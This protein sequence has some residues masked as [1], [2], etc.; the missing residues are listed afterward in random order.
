M[1]IDSEV[2][3]QVT[4]RFEV[5][6]P[7]LNE[8]QRRLVLAEE[9]RLIGHGGVRAV[10]RAAGV[11]ETTVRAGVFEL[12]RGNDPLPTGRVRQPGGGRKPLTEHDPKLMPA[13]L[14]LVEPDERG[15]PT[16]PLRW[17]TKSL[18]HLADE[19]TRQGHPVSAATVGRLLHRNGF[20]LQANAKTLEGDQHADRD[21]QFGYVNEQ[22]K[23]HQ[24]A[25]EPVISVDAKKKEQLGW[26]PNSGREWRPHR[27]PIKV[28]D[29]SF[30]IG[31][32]MQQALPYGVYDLTNDTGWVNVGVDHDTAAFAVASIRRWWQARGHFD[33][34]HA[35]R[36][37]ITAD[38]GGSNSY[39]FRL[40]KAELAALAAETGLTITVC[41]FPPG[42]SKWNKIEHR[43]FS[44]IT[45]NW[46][47]RPLTSHEVVV[48]T[49]AATT[50]R[51]GLRVHASLDTGDYP[52]GIAV[53][54]AQVQALPI[55]AHPWHGAWNYTISPP[56]PGCNRQPAADS[57]AAV[58][59]RARNLHRLADPRL[60]GMTRDELDRLISQLADDQAAQ[61]ERRCYQ[62]RG[63][64]RQRAPGA[65]GTMLL[66]AADR[67]LVTVIYLRQICSQKVLAELLAINPNSIGN[68]IA[69]TRTLLEQRKHT[70]T[71]T[72]LRCTSVS[73]L[74]SFLDDTAQP[75][76][77]I[78]LP[79]L[80][81]DP[82]LTGMTRR[83]LTG[84][85]DQ[86]RLPHNAQVEHRRYHRRGRHRLPGTRGGVF[87]QK[88]TDPERVLAAI[89]YQRRA[90][91]RQVLADL[92]NV[93]PRTIGNI[94]IDIRPLLDHAG[95]QPTPA[96]IRY[97]S[98]AA[99]R[100]AIGRDT[101]T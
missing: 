88:I 13:L 9:A 46:R 50:T 59:T 78:V 37:L 83:Q 25:G 2:L 8:R 4:T 21:A 42:T 40:W 43:L 68:A 93:S 22:V 81:T 69:D 86:L 33:Y 54:A 30:F 96:D 1:E 57:T 80:L 94:L 52:L 28:V 98:T 6:A 75:A 27:D 45:M 79:D 76:P 51:T 90:C 24:Q 92:F 18:R 26:L 35:T 49:I 12:E 36:L 55:T 101:P 16:S 70:I 38:A 65:G 44:H 61:T 66:T 48:Q 17:T 34:P 72:K 23:Q 84:L 73:Q 62:Q 19:L 11:S 74:L 71:P 7:H 58:Q 97:R 39:R 87:Q 99:L 41:H 5:L 82:R 63:G 53:S 77:A 29:H 67:I 14:A 64:S 91:T 95:Y 15:D 47:G 20:S 89:L 3:R 32:Q 85:L 31:P 10:A 60:T 100:E 56:G